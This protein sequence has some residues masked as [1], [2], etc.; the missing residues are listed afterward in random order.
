M[1]S[2]FCH[3]SLWGAVFGGVFSSGRPDLRAAVRLI[4]TP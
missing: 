1:M 2:G 4:A 3:F